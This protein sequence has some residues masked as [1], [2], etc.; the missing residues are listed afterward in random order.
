MTQGCDIVERYENLLK[1]YE[2]NKLQEEEE[3][4]RRRLERIG[5]RKNVDSDQKAKGK[6]KQTEEK[7]EQVEERKQIK[8]KRMKVEET[9][10]GN[11]EDEDDS[12]ASRIKRRS[13]SQR[14]K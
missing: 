9:K 1:F 3:W 8:E 2:E 6:R 14:V 13:R 5:T 11:E 10:G 7:R 12:I 4:V